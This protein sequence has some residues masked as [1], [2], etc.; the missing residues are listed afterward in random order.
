MSI[1]SKSI[2]ITILLIFF[3]G[4][5]LFSLLVFLSLRTENIINFIIL[6]VLAILVY[7]AFGTALFYNFGLI[8]LPGLLCALTIHF[9]F[10]RSHD[11]KLNRPCL[12]IL[13][14][15]SWIIGFTVSYFLA[16]V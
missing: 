9:L 15:I 7:T 10:F 5:P 1:L 4:S 3:V 11:N 16:Q 8:A 6:S 13:T 12:Y 14:T 2:I